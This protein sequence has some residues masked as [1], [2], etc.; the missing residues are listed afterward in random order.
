MIETKNVNVGDKVYYDPLKRFIGFDIKY[1][2]GI[3]KE[4]VDDEYVRVVYHCDNNWNN[5]Q[6]YTGAMTAVRDLYLGWK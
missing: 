1:E 6:D 3:I 5:Y 2:N 4:I